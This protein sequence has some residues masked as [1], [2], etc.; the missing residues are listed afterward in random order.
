MLKAIGKISVE[1]NR[2]RIVLNVSPDFVKLYYWFISKHYWIKMNQPLHGS[3]VTIFSEKHHS[4]VNWNK[5]MWYH[6][7]TLEF[8]Y[9]A[10]IKEGGYT[11][12][13]LMYYMLVFSSDLDQLKKKLGIVDSSNRNNL[14]I[15]IANS[16]GN[17]VY[18]DWPQMI[19]IKK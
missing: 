13:F 14:H 10:N 7:K 16:K 18:P 8:E 1:P 3:H 2:G 12:G 9:S 15:T 19:E 11:K 4:K 17:N 5:A 6:G